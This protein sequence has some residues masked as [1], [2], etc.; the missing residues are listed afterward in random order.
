M[1]IQSWTKEEVLSLIQPHL[2]DDGSLLSALHALQ[3]QY[4]FIDQSLIPYVAGLFNLTRAEVHGVVSFYHDFRAEKPGRHIIRI[5]QAEA[6]QATGSRA[7][8][9]HAG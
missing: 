6:C 9:D 5:C 1:N 2:D 3:K 7:L 8:T 4:G